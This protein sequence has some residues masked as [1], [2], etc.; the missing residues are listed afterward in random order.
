MIMQYRNPPGQESPLQSNWAI[1]PDNDNEKPEDF[2]VEV[3]R[4][5]MPS[6]EE[7]IARVSSVTFRERPEPAMLATGR[8]GAARAERE[9]HSYPVD[10]DIVK[11]KI[12][13]RSRK[14]TGVVK[15]GRL[16]FSNGETTEVGFFLGADDRVI[17]GR[18]TVP[19]GGILN[20]VDNPVASK[21]S[22]FG[23]S[24][25]A[26]N[27]WIEATLRSQP[28][29]YLA[30][31]KK[32]PR[33]PVLPNPPL[34]PTSMSFND[35]RAFA[36]LEPVMTDM[37]PCLPCGSASV[38][39]VFPGMRKKP[40]SNSGSQAWEDAAHGVAAREA[41]HEMIRTIP[42]IDREMLEVAMT[43]S[44]LEDIGAAAGH[45]GDYARKAG[46]RILLAVNENLERAA[47]KI[48]G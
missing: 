29:R 47:K 38:A 31:G 6:P 39:E 30:S 11:E 4:E 46:K 48:T 13:R 2:R 14:W 5:I 3:V 23:N 8:H 25:M 10:G 42:P 7:M 27:R 1:T 36:G 24:T 18:I 22:T 45:H 16:Q 20:T 43:A 37:R 35:A 15:L 40:A 21:G 34:P 44:S 19:A 17:K 28:F 9:V 41:W 12:N 32:K 26:S 33:R